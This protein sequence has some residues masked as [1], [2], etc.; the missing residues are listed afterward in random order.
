MEKGVFPA[1]LQLNEMGRQPPVLLQKARC[2]GSVQKARCSGSGSGS[3]HVTCPLHLTAALPRAA[4]RGVC[5]CVRV[6]V[7]VVVC[8]CVCALVCVCMRACVRVCL[9]ACMH[10]CMC[11]CVYVCI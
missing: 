7:C 11:V 6:C 2:S 4:S 5:V 8:V 10:A 1:E 9:L 3:A